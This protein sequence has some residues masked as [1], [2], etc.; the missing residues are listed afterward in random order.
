MLG[1]IAAG[2]LLGAATLAL[3]KGRK[4]PQ[5]QPVRIGTKDRKTA[6]RR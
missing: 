5:A 3:L 6:P 1:V 2:I 4:G